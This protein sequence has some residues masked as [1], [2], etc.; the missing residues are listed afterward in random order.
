MQ[1]TEVVD[2]WLES[3]LEDELV[4]HLGCQPLSIG[5]FH[6]QMPSVV[7]SGEEERESQWVSAAVYVRYLSNVISRATDTNHI[8][9]PSELAI[10][11]NN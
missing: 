8:V 9:L 11:H 10:V 6:L 3:A 5:S 7:A 4:E 2:V 1:G